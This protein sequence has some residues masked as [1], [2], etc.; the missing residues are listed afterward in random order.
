[1]DALCFSWLTLKEKRYRGTLAPW[2]VPT[3]NLLCPGQSAV[4]YDY[5]FSNLYGGYLIMEKIIENWSPT[6]YKLSEK[7]LKIKIKKLT[8]DSNF[9][10]MLLL[11]QHYS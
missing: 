2:A 4:T 10:L 7:N 6:V 8:S 5:L 9:A 11:K 3:Y 1:M